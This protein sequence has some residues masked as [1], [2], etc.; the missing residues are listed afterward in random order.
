MKIKF[1]KP[2][3]SS[4]MIQIQCMMV[5]TSDDLDT[6]LNLGGVLEADL[7]KKSFLATN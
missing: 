1:P 6:V 7:K 3:C 2:Y 5:I 4:T